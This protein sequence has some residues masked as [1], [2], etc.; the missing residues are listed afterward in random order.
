MRPFVVRRQFLIKGLITS[1]RCRSGY[2]G[3]YSFRK[4]GAH[5]IP[6]R[7]HPRGPPLRAPPHTLLI[8]NESQTK[9]INAI[10]S[11][12]GCRHFFEAIYGVLLIKGAFS[13]DRID[14]WQSGVQRRLRILPRIATPTAKLMEFVIGKVAVIPLRILRPQKLGYNSTEGD[15]PEG[16]WADRAGDEG[17]SAEREGAGS[18]RTESGGED[19]S[20]SPRPPATG[21]GD[22]ALNSLAPSRPSIGD[23]SPPP[24]V[25]EADGGRA[26]ISSSELS[27]SSAELIHFPRRQVSILRHSQSPAELSDALS[28]AP[29]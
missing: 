28:A 12:L 5:R 7:P 6:T 21:S 8:R 1:F 24:L 23:L 27:Q 10:T 14:S 13:F 22:P 25:P 9:I 17:T 26:S 29:P 4:R 3:V 15:P 16:I 19:A 18:T 11:H 20:E 2:R